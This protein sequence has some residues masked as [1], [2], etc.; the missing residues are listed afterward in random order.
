MRPPTA[1]IRTAC[2]DAV[3]M[4]PSVAPRDPN[5]AKLY[6]RAPRIGLEQARRA[7]TQEVEIEMLMLPECRSQLHLS[8]AVQ[9]LG[10]ALSAAAPPQLL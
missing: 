7:A 5:P 2:G 9:P 3:G 10:G 1:P 6:A 4:E 8:V